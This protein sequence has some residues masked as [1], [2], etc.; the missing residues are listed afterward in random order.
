MGS[1]WPFVGRVRELDRIAVLVDNAVGVLVLGD[2]GVGKTALAR[3]AEQ[4]SADGRAPVGRVFGHAVSNG[5][6][7]EAFAGVLT[8][9][10]ASLLSPVEVARQVAAALGASPARR[11]LFVVDD[12][13]L[14]DERS[15]QVLL[16]LAA[17]GT[18]TV[19]ATARRDVLPAGVDR[20]WRDGLCERVEMVGLTDAEVHEVIEAALDAPVDPAAA[21]A[22]AGWSEGNPLLLRE[23]VGAA[24][25][26]S[27][28]VWRGTAWTLTGPAP[29]STGV[30]D[31]ARARLAG[32]PETQRRA[33]E[34]IAA[35]EPLALD[36]AVDLVG[37]SMLD[38]LDADRLI[39]VRTGLAG[40]EVGSA[41][42]LHGEV[43]RA[44]TPPLRMRRVRLALASRLEA[45]PDPSPHDLV[46]AA[47]WRLESGQADDAERL[48]TAARAAR[49]LSL[50]TAERLAR[51]AHEATGSLQATLLLAE[52]L[53]HT[54]RS[55]EAAALTAG[56]PP[57]SLTPDDREALVY[58]TAVGERLMAGDA[59]GGADIV[60]GVLA[61]DPA[62]SDMLRGL[63]ASLLA[64]DARFA[65]ALD[66][67]AAVFDDPAASPVAR[68]FAAVGTVAAEYWLGHTRRAVAQ[69]DEIGPIAETVRDAVP[70]GAP[71]IEL[72]AIC[73]L[74]DE[75]E[76]DRAQQRAQRMQQ[77]A[78]A[79][80][81]MFSGSR[82]EYCVGRIAL[83]R[84]LPAT[85]LRGFRRC[86]ATLTRFDESFVRHISSMLSRA[87]AAAGDL[88]TCQDI[89]E[90]CAHATR[91]KIYEPE[92]ELARAAAHAAQLR[93][94]EAAEHAAWAAGTAADRSQ[95][96]V[97]V[98]GYHDAARYGAARHIL[99]PMKQA[100]VQV[101]G[102]FAGTLLDHASALAARD[103]AALD[104][105]AHRF[106]A[107]GA[108]RFAAEAAAEAAMAHTAVGDARP[109]RASAARAAKLWSRCE[110]PVP[111][112]LAGADVAAPLT[113]RERQIA[114]LAADGHSDTAI[115]ARLGISARTVQ[116][117]L[118]RVYSKLGITG[119]G[120]I[121]AH[122][123]SAGD[124]APSRPGPP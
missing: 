96:N 120:E 84:G 98:A 8:A 115:A 116:T 20:L 6:P 13:H 83:A 79:N 118:A 89:L 51:R 81:D 95:W 50:E 114:A 38:Q 92:F 37:E 53:T 30:R 45:A 34:T 14:L 61:G 108:L 63:H 7:F 40:P 78:A 54:R 103:P 57:D 47:L 15:A 5:A 104:A 17:E 60:G 124:R 18:A 71:S 22:F 24:L 93:L 67:G 64:F 77:R 73:A 59:G 52:I 72:V 99:I 82:A 26:R 31:L 43:L 58:C 94:G 80:Q 105:M 101:D 29:L 32:L 10:T 121:A 62:A 69:A 97:A 119:R 91:M 12:A 46:R 117:H 90:S 28:L 44:D 11:A 4:R 109:A 123:G 106:E 65:E 70:F 113:A 39:T 112:W 9:P 86:L 76:L 110:G 85:A 111:P 16:Q 42:P 36:V 35:G 107:H 49:S 25:D 1:T 68:T 3:Q 100:A 102:T 74:H 21:R 23:L 88:A 19:L 87:A 56:L 66:V 55:A 48:L 33:L 122:L 2:S 75:G 27:A 41:H